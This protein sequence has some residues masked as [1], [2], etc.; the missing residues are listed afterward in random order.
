MSVVEEDFTQRCEEI[1]K[2]LE[3]LAELESQTGIDVTLMATMKASALLMIYNLVESTASNSIESI[4]DHLKASGLG[5]VEVDDRLKIMVLK[6]AKKSNPEK[7]VGRMRDAGLDFAVASFRKDEIF[8]GNVD[9]KKIRE[10]W[11]EYGVDRSDGYA[12]AVLLE[13]KSARN[14]LAHGAKSFAEL[15][16]SLSVGDIKEKH[17]KA[18]ALLLMAVRDVKKHIGSKLS[19]AA[20]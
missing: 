7:L 5:F 8:S 18:K 13:I 19:K 12:E 16:R 6:C 10:M 15:G 4:Y 11:D 2:Y 9:S 3:Y 17:E 20:A 14:D 1:E